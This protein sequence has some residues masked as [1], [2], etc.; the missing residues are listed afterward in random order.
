MNFSWWRHQMENLLA[1]CAGNS[2]VTGEFPV[3]KPVMRSFGV[4]FDLYLNKRL[5]K[6]SRRRWSETPWRSFWR[7]YNGLRR[8]KLNFSP[9]LRGPRLVVEG[10]VPLLNYYTPET[11]FGFTRCKFS[12][13]SERKK[14]THKQHFCIKVFAIPTSGCVEAHFCAVV[15]LGKDNS[16]LWENLTACSLLYRVEYISRNPNAVVILLC[17]VVLC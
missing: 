16:K 7:H 9:D 6:Q 1:F 4:L 10:V 12:Q 5:G 3:Q 8:N 15:M 17:L 14:D 2:P 13:V 11:N